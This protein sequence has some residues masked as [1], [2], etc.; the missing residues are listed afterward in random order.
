[1]SVL[2]VEAVLDVLLVLGCA[3]VL[4]CALAS[5]DVVEAGGFA[6]AVVS[7]EVVVD[8]DAWFDAVDWL[9]DG[10]AVDALAELSGVAVVDDGLATAEVW[11][12]VEAGVCVLSGAPVDD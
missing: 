7:G 11:L 8:E 6:A 4:D 2:L 9:L 3:A 12:P 5:G 1:M 10:A